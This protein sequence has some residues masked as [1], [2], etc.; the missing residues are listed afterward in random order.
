MSIRPAELRDAAAYADHVVVHMAESGKDGAPIF[1]PGHRSSREEIRDNAAARW[2]RRLTD[3]LWGR[4]W[5]LLAPGDGVVG[6][7]ELRGG[8]ISTEMHRATLGM[9]I[10]RAYTGRGH[11]KRLLDAAI[12][13]ARAETEIAWI[14][15]GVFVGNEPAR[16]LYE[17]YGFV[18]EFIRRDAFR[19]EDGTR[20][21]D[22]QM[23]LRIR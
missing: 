6:H 19:L 1:A 7:I 16:K 14:D 3:P 4:E 2:A 11:G 8:R 9:G 17:R 18:P 10:L 15:L 12:G 21:D 13:W 20:I 22:M 23:T 5:L